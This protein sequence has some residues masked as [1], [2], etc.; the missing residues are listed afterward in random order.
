MTDT[1]WGVL[2]KM[3]STVL[4][5]AAGGGGESPI[6]ITNVKV[7]MLRMQECLSSDVLL[8]HCTAAHHVS[9]QCSSQ[10]CVLA[11]LFLL[12]KHSASRDLTATRHNN[13]KQST[14]TQMYKHPF[15]DDK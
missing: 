4:D 9:V 6:L 3:L 5:A 8:N 13:T 11:A 12:C 15:N 2:H 1:G 14:P 7:P 10:S